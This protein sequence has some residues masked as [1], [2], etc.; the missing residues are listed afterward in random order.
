MI[1]SGK[2]ISHGAYLKRYLIEKRD[3]DF[4]PEVFRIKGTGTPDNYD[5]SADELILSGLLSKG[6]KNI[7]HLQINPAIGEDNLSDEQWQD[8]IDISMRW[9]KLEDQKYVAV[10][11]TKK[12]RSHMHVMIDRY[13]YD[14]G[15]L[16]SDSHD[17][18]KLEKAADELAEMLGHEM[19]VRKTD[20][21]AHTIH[22][23][24]LTELWYNSENPRDFIDDAAELDYHVAKG[25]KNHPWR[26]I[27]PDG[28]SLNLVKQIDG[29]KTAD[30][31]DL[32]K[33][34]TLLFEADAL[35]MADEK[36][37][38]VA[39]AK[40]QFNDNL[41]S[42]KFLKDQEDREKEKKQ[43]SRLEA[44]VAGH[45]ALENQEVTHSK[46]KKSMENI[47]EL[48]RRQQKEYADLLEKQRQEWQSLQKQYNSNISL[49]VA[50]AFRKYGGQ[51]LRELA[52]QHNQERNNNADYVKVMNIDRE[53]ILAE[54]AAIKEMEEI[55]NQKAN[56]QSV[57]QKIAKEAEQTQQ[58]L[59][60]QEKIKQ[61]AEQKRLYMEQQNQRKLG[62]HKDNGQEMTR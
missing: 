6:D 60:R 14:L 41:K 50:D 44:E 56:E 43:V 47:D 30:V 5:L 13:D 9:A 42:E 55:V 3:N 21:T 38:A 59:D 54:Q 52:L 29:V 32:L 33:R 19:V 22:K 35:R 36:K 24:I 58:E 39:L 8:C 15:I 37:I 11:H 26:V 61:Q 17:W 12:D 49:D 34:E 2:S 46:P 62:L 57:F 51:E 20:R 7:Y 4:D 28:K 16:R 10:K 23:E 31:A 45:E 53:M 40:E 1:L 25:L 48:A 27:T 18:R